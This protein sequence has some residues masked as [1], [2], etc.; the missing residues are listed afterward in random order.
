MLRLAVK[1]EAGQLNRIIIQ[2][3]TR[4]QKTGSKQWSSFLD[5]SA[6]PEV[7]EKI[8]NEEAYIWES[9]GSIAA[10]L[11]ASKTPNSWDKILWGSKA[12]EPAY[13]IHRVAVADGFQGKGIPYA[14]LKELQDAKRGSLLRLDC[15]A[16]QDV[17]NRLYKEAGFVHIGVVKDHPARGEQIADFNLYEY[18]FM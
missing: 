6:L 5:G 8:E 1:E 15:V 3:A 7:K 14:M 4:I 11:Y 10:M 2:A 13:Y 18:R 17:L 16:H 12:A 9:D